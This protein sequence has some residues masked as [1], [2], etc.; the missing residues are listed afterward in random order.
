MTE[1]PKKRITMW[2][3]RTVTG[4]NNEDGERSPAYML[5]PHRNASRA[6]DSGGFPRG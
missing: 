4:G 2:T 3:M 1:D 6:T 5:E